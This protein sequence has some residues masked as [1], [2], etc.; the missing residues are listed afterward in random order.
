MNSLNDMVNLSIETLSK[1]S[2]NRVR[3]IFQEAKFYSTDF[4][5]FCP[6]CGSFD[7]WNIKAT[8]IQQDKNNNGKEYIERWKCKGCNNHYSITTNTIFENHKYPLKTY[9]LSIFLFI[10]SVKGL[11]SLQLSRDLNISPK[12]SFVLL[13]KIRTALFNQYKSL[14]SNKLNGTIQMDGAYINYLPKKENKKKDRKD[15]REL[16]HKS[17]ECIIT[18]REVND[19]VNDRSFAFIIK[20][21]NKEDIEN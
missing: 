2:E 3:K 6:K 18:M 9:L 8:K 1:L 7:K 17:Q 20:N 14:Q 21:E 5:P 16:K 10:N 11:S 19:N 13:H 4:K 12:Y 15:R